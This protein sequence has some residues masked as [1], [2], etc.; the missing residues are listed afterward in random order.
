ML[1]TSSQ[2]L[3][4]MLCN[5][6]CKLTPNS[7]PGVYQLKCSCGG[8]YIGETKKRILIRSI[9][10]QQN[11]LKGNWEESGVTEHCKSCHGRFNWLHPKTVSVLPD[12]NERK[13]R[14]SLEINSLQS[15]SE[16]DT[17]LTVLNRDNGNRVNT[18]S[19]KPF[20]WKFAQSLNWW[21]EHNAKRIFYIL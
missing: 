2:N 21:R 4:T 15:R 20:F 18:A 3:K 12:F 8:T 19:W 11:S 17:T 9:E 13:I 1:F 5:N 6:K 14:E 7:H 16:Y 10:H